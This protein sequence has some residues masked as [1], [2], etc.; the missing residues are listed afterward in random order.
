MPLPLG[1]D[2]LYDLSHPISMVYHSWTYQRIV[3]MIE[4]PLL[5]KLTSNQIAGE[6]VIVETFTKY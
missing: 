5:E 6:R 4:G 3:K 2:I 1:F